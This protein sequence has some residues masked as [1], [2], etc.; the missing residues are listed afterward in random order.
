[1]GSLFS[2]SL[3]KIKSDI[4]SQ[5]TSLYNNYSKNCTTRK[6]L[7]SVLDKK[8]FGS[9]LQKNM[10][11]NDKANEFFRKERNKILDKFDLV[12]RNKELENKINSLEENQNNRNEVQQLRDELSKNNYRIR[13]LETQNNILLSQIRRQQNDLIKHQ[14]YLQQIQM[15]NQEEMKKKKSI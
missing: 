5:L 4:D 7:E 11:G 12:L 13:D 2:P 14:N 9:E 6:D 1:M 8:Y 15:Q 10:N 3:D